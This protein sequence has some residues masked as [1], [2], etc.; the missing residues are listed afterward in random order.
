MTS[1]IGTELPANI[2]Q[3][4]AGVLGFSDSY[5]LSQNPDVAAAVAAG[6]FASGYQHFTQHGAREGRNPNNTFNS[7]YYLIAN[8]DVANAIASG[9]LSSAFEHYQSFGW[10]EGRKPSTD[11]VGLTEFDYNQYLSAYPDLEAAGITTP[12]QAYLH[13][14]EFGASEQRRAQTRTGLP[15]AFGVPVQP[16]V[17]DSHSTP[18]PAPA[19][20]LFLRAGQSYTFND[21]HP[22]V[23]VGDGDAFVQ[24]TDWDEIIGFV[25]SRDS[26]DLPTT[27]TSGNGYLSNNILNVTAVTTANYFPSEYGFFRGTLVGNTFTVDTTGGADTLIYWTDGGP[28][29]V[30]AVIASVTDL[31]T[32]NI[33]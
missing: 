13:Y 23:N 28:T 3:Y 21:I 20:A 32:S 26:I 17:G 10:S 29:K 33:V 24:S 31:T 11:F 4:L 22:F 6:A 1:S 12:N 18:A 19:P 27:A 7:E 2:N 8:P 9:L 25:S 14:I 15:L 5:Y 16:S 30:A